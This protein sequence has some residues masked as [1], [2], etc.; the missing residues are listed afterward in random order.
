MSLVMSGLD[1]HRT[2]LALRQKLAFGKQE[3]ADL[4]TRL[5]QNCRCVLLST[6]NRTELYI[7]GDTET[8]WRLLCQEAGVD[9]TTLEACFVTRTG[10]DAARHLMEVACGLHSQILG[11]DQIITQV[12]TAMDLARDLKT[13]DSQLSALFRHAVTAGKRAKTEV[14]I[15]RNAPSLGTRCKDVLRQE[16]GSL[17]GKQILIIGNGQM[18]R[19]C[20]ELLLED[21]ACVHM[22]YRTYRPQ[23]PLVPAGC[24][25]IPYDMRTA[26]LE[27][28]DVVISATSSPH[29]PLNAHHLANARHIPQIMIDLAIPRDIDPVWG[30]KTQLYDLDSLGQSAPGS[31]EELCQ[32][33]QIADEALQQFLQWKQRQQSRVPRF[34]LFVDLTDK[35]VVIVG[36]G[37]I[38]SRRIS[39]LRQFGCR[40]TVI[41][42]TLNSKPD[43]I[44]WLQRPYRSGDLLGAFLAIAA[45]DD[46][47]V[48]R[49]V[50]E[51][52]RALQIPVS[53][54]DCEAECTF[55]FPAIC[56][57]SNLIAGLVS[58]DGDHH[59]TVRAAKAVRRVL[60]ELP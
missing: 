36:G 12:R 45:T 51:E 33:N 53:V 1:F 40:I 18:G 23:D 59:Q 15:N 17:T 14:S 22:T 5:G 37:V 16:L 4:L 2:P 6:C 9:E 55:Y 19:L 11:D 39:V 24:N 44:T 50:G 3:R 54:A 32:L 58:T 25:P 41:A 48:N 42:P 30:T 26:V 34:P 60:E 57:G 8:P 7:S 27:Q 52:A 35:S 38:A 56:T 28:A 29:C 47:A 43:G 46:R 31:E 49:Q 13:C 20:A 21:G 10:A